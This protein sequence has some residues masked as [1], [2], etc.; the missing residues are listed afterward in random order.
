MVKWWARLSGFEAASWHLLQHFLSST[1]ASDCGW[2]MAPVV[3]SLG[4]LP[5]TNR[6][7]V[8]C[9]EK[10]HGNHLWRYFAGPRPSLPSTYLCVCPPLPFWWLWWWSNTTKILTY[11]KWVA[12]IKLNVAF[13]HYIVFPALCE[14]PACM[15]IWHVQTVFANR[16]S[17]VDLR[18]GWRCG[19]YLWGWAACIISF[20][21]R[22]F[23]P[24]HGV[25]V[26]SW[27]G[28]WS[29][30]PGGIRAPVWTGNNRHALS[31]KSSKFT[32]RN[33]IHI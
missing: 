13:S 4:P 27:P 10:H 33:Y 3:G 22:F 6:H 25:Q 11:Y 18:P 5:I 16:Y 8:Y 29:K 1:F 17:W 7:L 9:L 14:P 23:L 32:N 24:I 20:L 12:H 19:C 26:P 31:S 2:K 28:G 30:E 15:T 21:W